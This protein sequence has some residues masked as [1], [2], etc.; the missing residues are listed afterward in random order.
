MLDMLHS[1]VII[2]EMEAFHEAAELARSEAVTADAE[3]AVGALAQR[4]GNLERVMAKAVP[5]S[6]SR[7]KRNE[8]DLTKE[9]HSL[10]S[11]AKE[12]TVPSSH[13]RLGR[14]VADVC[15]AIRHIEGDA[16]RCEALGRSLVNAW[17]RQQLKMATIGLAGPIGQGTTPPGV[18]ANSGGDN[19]KRG[20]EYWHSLREAEAKIK[21]LEYNASKDQED[22]QASKIHNEQ[23]QAVVA[24]LTAKLESQKL[25]GLEGS[26]QQQSSQSRGSSYRRPHPNTHVRYASEM[27]ASS[28]QPGIPEVQG[29]YQ[30]LVKR[31]APTSEYEGY[32]SGV[33]AL[34]PAYNMTPE[35]QERFKATIADVAARE[36]TV[37]R[38]VPYAMHRSFGGGE[39]FGGVSKSHSV[40][41]N[42]AY[43][44]YQTTSDA[45]RRFQR[46]ELN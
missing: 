1:D 46:L 22:L 35:Q 9:S 19:E 32:N 7:V 6:T 26:L 20:P 24:Q 18:P 33:T 4:L 39:A 31:S 44:P 21:L 25:A 12:H 34:P 40:V 27:E 30:S 42:E 8:S 36:K 23:L 3:R 11:I 28:E 45:N 5:M 43:S 38:S 41:G 14:C 10:W 15:A 17:E 29:S 37:D 2:E 13:A 16:M